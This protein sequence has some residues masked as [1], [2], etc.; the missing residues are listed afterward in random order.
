MTS[1]E[2][3]GTHA[4]QNPQGSDHSKESKHGSGGHSWKMYLR[5]GAMILTGMVVMYWVM[6]V[7][8]WEWSHVRFSESRVFMA[9]TMGGTM[10]LVMLAWMLNMY[11]NTKANI[12]VVA[13]SV[14]LIGGGIAFDR[15]QITVDDTDWMSAMIPHHSLAITRSERAQ[16]QDVRVCELAAEISKA[17]RNEILEMDWL[18]D[19][20]Q[21][22]GVADTVEEAE[23][24]PAP[25]FDR[26]AQR[27]CPTQ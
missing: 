22:N 8:S 21:R 7:G 12:A 24:R 19:D 9:L 5:F 25:T 26:T 27:Q 13:A 6:F 11:K 1:N 20:I 17:Q 23:A 4:H 16:I 18:I 10:G 3:H 15:S 14:L 2:Q